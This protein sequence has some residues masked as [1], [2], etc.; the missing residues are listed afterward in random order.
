MRLSE[1]FPDWEEWDPAERRARESGFVAV[2]EPRFSRFATFRNSLF[3]EIPQEPVEGTAA[4][5]ANDQEFTQYAIRQIE[6]ERQRQRDL[7]NPGVEKRGRLIGGVRHPETSGFGHGDPRYPRLIDL[8]VF[9]PTTFSQIFDR[10]DWLRASQ[11]YAAEDDARNRR[12]KQS[13]T[14]EDRAQKT[15]QKKSL[16]KRALARFGLAKRA[17]EESKPKNPPKKLQKRHPSAPKSSGKGIYQRMDEDIELRPRAKTVTEHP[18]MMHPTRSEGSRGGHPGGVSQH[19]P[20]PRGQHPDAGR[21]V[22]KAPSQTLQMQP[23]SQIRPQDNQRY[24]IQPSQS[25]GQGQLLEST[26]GYQQH[27]SQSQYQS[28]QRNQ[29]PSQRQVQFQPRPSQSH[30]QPQQTSRSQEQT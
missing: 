8:P 17:E 22:Y 21:H 26:Q 20:Q 3:L 28:S 13:V 9:A 11:K 30:N 24:Q 25:R 16:W 6:A 19:P 1:F 12:R 7:Q 4:D 27:P 10:D 29:Q 15:A 23:R 2:E 5:V 14:S 18:A